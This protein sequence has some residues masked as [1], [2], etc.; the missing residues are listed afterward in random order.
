M[1]HATY[2]FVAILRVEPGVGCHVRNLFTEETRL[3]VDIGFSKTAKPGAVLA[4]RLLDFGGFAAT[5][6][7]ALSLGA[8]VG[9]AKCSRTVVGNAEAGLLVAPGQSFN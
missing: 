5:G 9:V 1:Q 7:A 3:L 8:G 2:A 6:D 4:T